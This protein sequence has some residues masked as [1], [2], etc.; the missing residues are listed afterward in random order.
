MPD[1][2]KLLGAISQSS[3]QIGTVLSLLLALTGGFLVAFWISLVLWTFHDIRSRTRDIFAI[4]LATLMVFLFGPVGLIL[5][6]LL[7]PR[8]TL[9]E[10][11][12]RQL[13]QEALL[14]DITEQRACPK[15]HRPIEEDF[16]LCPYCRTPLKK[17]CSQCGRL[18]HLEWTIC[19]YC[20]NEAVGPRVHALAPA[21]EAE[22]ERVAG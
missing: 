5:Y 2:G 8:E 20:G 15:C 9:D 22:P 16:R 7:R 3:N 18:L 10:V 4:L 6:F 17:P 19:P 13:A 12:E 11:Y 1:I 21:E 14:Q